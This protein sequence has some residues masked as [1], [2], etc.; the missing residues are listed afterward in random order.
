MEDP[1]LM[2]DCVST[3]DGELMDG[4]VESIRNLIGQLN[5]T[6]GLLGIEA[7]PDAENWSRSEVIEYYESGGEMTGE[8]AG[9]NAAP[10]PSKKPIEA[11]SFEAAL[12]RL[13]SNELRDD[14]VVT[15]WKGALREKEKRRKTIPTLVEVVEE[16]KKENAEH[17]R[18]VCIAL[19]ALV[20][21]SIAASGTEV[22]DFPFPM[23]EVP[24]AVVVILGWAGSAVES[25]GDVARYYQRDFPGF[26]VITTVGG[27]DR[28]AGNS[29]EGDGADWFPTE[30]S[31]MYEDQLEHVLACVNR[32]GRREEG[33]PD[34]PVF[35]HLFSNNG[36]LAYQRVLQAMH[37]HESGGSLLSRLQAGGVIADGTP[38]TEYSAALMS[39]VVLNSVASAIRLCHEEEGAAITASDATTMQGGKHYLPSD[40]LRERLRSFVETQGT[41]LF[42]CSEHVRTV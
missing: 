26:K 6:Y 28:W 27:C 32:N 22:L 12:D 35:M 38:E 37:K 1:D 24:Q 36:F 21:L 29:G 7:P 3:L 20:F 34:A 42:D 19:G 15:C 40:T 18:L 16:A 17:D 23:N 9:T 2:G 11:P 10:A 30:V 8:A 25:L 41:A 4:F 31:D 33:Q 5:N 14:D 13:S 39:R